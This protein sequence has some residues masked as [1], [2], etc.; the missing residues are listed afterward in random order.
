MRLQH[1]PVLRVQAHGG[2]LGFCAQHVQGFAQHGHQGLGVGAQFLAHHLAGNVARQLQQIG[3]D[4]LLQ[5]LNAVLRL[6]DNF[7]QALALLT[8][9]VVLVVLH[10][11]L[12]LLARLLQALLQALCKAFLACLLQQLLQSLFIQR[13]CGRLGLFGRG[14]IVGFGQTCRILQRVLCRCLLH[15]RLQA[16]ATVQGRQHTAPW[17]AQANIAKAP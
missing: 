7:A 5:A 13:R 11:L 3:C 17:G 6:M 2:G 12:P 8:P 10:A 9:L 16:S 15:Q 4:L 14:S 1:L